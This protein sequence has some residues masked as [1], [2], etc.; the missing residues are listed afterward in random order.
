MTPSELLERARAGVAAAT[1]TFAGA[2]GWTWRHRTAV[3]AGAVVLLVAL[4]ATTCRRASSAEKAV[5]AATKRAAGEAKA[6]ALGIPVAHELEQPAVDEEAERLRKENPVL[7]A[8]HERDE[9][10]IGKLRTELAAH[11]ETAP[12]PALVPVAKGEQ[13][14]LGA[15]L[16]VNRTEDGAHILT[17]SLEARLAASGELVLRQPYS[18]PVTIAAIAASTAEARA[19][20]PERAWRF[21]A[22]GGATGQGWVAGGLVTYRLDLWGWRPEAL[23]TVAAGP[24]GV[25]ALAGVAF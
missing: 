17:G 24:G 2:A 20:A 14:R 25:V 18:A 23:G 16:E 21:G 1:P 15:D 19:A 13:L 12:A 5:E 10:L 7:R 11:V 6:E 3:L 4:N 8:Q 22:A 9:K